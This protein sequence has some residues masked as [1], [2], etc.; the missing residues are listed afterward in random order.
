MEDILNFFLRSIQALISFLMFFDSISLDQ[1]VP[2]WTIALHW[3]HI[4]EADY[5]QANLQ[6]QALSPFPFKW[7]VPQLTKLSHPHLISLS[8]ADSLM[9]MTKQPIKACLGIVNWNLISFHPS[10]SWDLSLISSRVAAHEYSP[11]AVADHKAK[12]ASSIIDNS[13]SKLMDINLQLGAN[14][15]ARGKFSSHYLPQIL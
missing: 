2:L 5:H 9:F 11:D 8:L 14:G 10:A 3:S 4:W 7:A 6:I 13:K 1:I 15:H 12:V